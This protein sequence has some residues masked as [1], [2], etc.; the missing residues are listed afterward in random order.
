MLRNM[1]D[2]NVTQLAQTLDLRSLPAPWLTAVQEAAERARHDELD[3]QFTAIE[4]SYPAVATSLRRLLDD[5]RFDL[6]QQLCTDALANQPP[7]Q[8]L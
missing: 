7:T 3:A 4:A 5:F 2:L 1:A 8:N 6:I